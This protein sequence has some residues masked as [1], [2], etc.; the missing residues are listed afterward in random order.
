[1]LAFLVY[2]N[3]YIPHAIVRARSRPSVLATWYGLQ[4]PVHFVSVYLLVRAFGITGAALAWVVRALIDAVGHR[5][6]AA[7]ELHGRL[8]RHEAWIPPAAGLGCL[9][10]FEAVPS[11]GWPLRFGLGVLVVVGLWFALRQA[12]DRQ[13]LQR[14]MVPWAR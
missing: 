3:V 6:L 1:M 11:M 12:G 9:A 10:L 7:R 2:A 4:L 13:M 8:G 14:A 5:V